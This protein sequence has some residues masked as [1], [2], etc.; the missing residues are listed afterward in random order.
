LFSIRWTY[1]C[2]WTSW[3]GEG[4]GKDKGVRLCIRNIAEEVTAEKLRE[5]ME[6]FDTI[7]AVTGLA[8]SVFFMF[9]SHPPMG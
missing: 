5:L 9:K 2:T 6:P 1:T 4:K 3:T 8:I 7:L